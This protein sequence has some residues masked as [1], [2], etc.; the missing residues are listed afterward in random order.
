MGRLRAPSMVSGEVWE[1]GKLMKK[2]K[3]KS[4]GGLW[5]HHW[6]TVSPT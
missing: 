3:P 5:R 2:M 6:P 1:Q 4:E